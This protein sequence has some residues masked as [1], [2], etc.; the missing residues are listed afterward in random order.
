MLRKT[1]SRRILLTILFVV[2]LAV[3]IG[4]ALGHR[5]SA[6]AKP[7]F[8]IDT[9][10]YSDAT[11]TTVIGERYIPCDGQ[12]WSWGTTSAYYETSTESCGDPLDPYHTC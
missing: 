10:Y 1:L 9:L 5:N 12:T 11:Y 4:A 8:S 7:C 3:A 2:A 6:S